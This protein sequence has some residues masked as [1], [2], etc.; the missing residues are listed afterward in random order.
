MKTQEV[1]AAINKMM[2]L[3]YIKTPSPAELKKI[4][5]GFRDKWRF[6]QVAGAIDT[7]VSQPPLI[8]LPIITTERDSTQ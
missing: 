5:Q 4:V 2:R 6:P 3:L 8:I 7:Y 1:V